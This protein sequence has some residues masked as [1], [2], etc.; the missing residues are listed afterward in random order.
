MDL[1]NDWHDWI[2]ENLCRGNSIESIRGV[3][4]EKGFRSGDVDEALKAAQSNPLLAT[5]RR[6]L[7]RYQKLAWTMRTLAA[8]EAERSVGM[9]VDRRDRLSGSD[10]FE[11]YYFASRPVVITGMMRGWPAME[12]WKDPGYLKERLG[13]F[14]VEVQADRDSDPA[15][16]LVQHRH[17]HWVKFAEF[18]DRVHSTGSSNDFYMTASNADRH[19][20]FVDA[21]LEDVT[22]PPDYCSP[23]TQ[24]RAFFW[25]GPAG[26]VTPLH[27]DMTN[28]LMA[29]VVGR[30]HVKLVSPLYA[31][32]VY[33]HEHCYAQ[34]DPE[35]PDFAKFPN[36]RDVVVLDVDLGP[37]EMLFIPVGWWHHVRALDV[38][39]TVSCT[40]FW[41]PNNHNA[42]YEGLAG[43]L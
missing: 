5:A 25:Y 35:S 15:Y 38:S 22:L 43:P 4:L 19:P 1:D 13:H 29:Q 42:G 33:N 7:R 6:F 27:H 10:F 40:N 21:A 37:G 9:G 30:K 11:D 18:V 3:L 32:A 20:A 23:D 26:T 17:R 14:S 8:H 31:A 12:R 2:G 41:P 34:V 28:N 16:E 24:G 36:F 39:I